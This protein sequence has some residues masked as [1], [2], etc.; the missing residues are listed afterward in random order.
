MILEV[1]FTNIFKDDL[2]LARKQNKNIDKLMTVINKIA[3]CQQLEEKYKDH[4]LLGKYSGTR[5]CHIEPNWLLI[6]EVMEE[7]KV[8]VLYRTGSHSKLFR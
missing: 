4:A 5:E 2:K 1:K 8:L 6:Y 3:N 7:D